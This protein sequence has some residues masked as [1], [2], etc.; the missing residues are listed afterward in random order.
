MRGLQSLLA[1]YEKAMSAAAGMAFLVGGG[2]GRQ[3]QVTAA[4][5]MNFFVGAPG[6]RFQDA[7]LGAPL[8]GL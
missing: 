7:R 5:L 4:A 6:V 1:A 3:Q 8:Q 2:A